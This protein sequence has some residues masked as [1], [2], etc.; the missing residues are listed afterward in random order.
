VP[1]STQSLER[2]LARVAEEE[3]V[4][5]PEPREKLPAADYRDEDRG[6]AQDHDPAARSPGA[7]AAGFGRH[8][9]AIRPW[10]RQF[11]TWQ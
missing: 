4:D 10:G 2:D 1:C 8:R 6:A 7:L 9:S 3:R 5:D 11:A